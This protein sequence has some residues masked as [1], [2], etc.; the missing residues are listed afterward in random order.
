[1]SLDLL[2]YLPLYS[3]KSS[4]N[5]KNKRVKMKWI[6]PNSKKKGERIRTAPLF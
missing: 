4:Q 1:M 5:L 2:A 6:L 3:V